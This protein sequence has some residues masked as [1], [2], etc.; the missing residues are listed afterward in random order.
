MS[1][2]KIA[3]SLLLLLVAASP[4]LAKPTETPVDL[5]EVSCV[6]IPG[7]TWTSGEMFHLRG[8]VSQSVLYD[9]ETLEVV[10]GNAILGNANLN[11]TTS[12]GVFFGT[13]SG[14]YLPASTTGTFDG[15]WTIHVSSGEFSGQAVARGTGE[16]EGQTMRVR[17]VGLTDAETAALLGELATQGRLPCP[18]ASIAGITRDIG[19]I[20]DPRGE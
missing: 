4:A 5:L 20:L 11:P 13:S 16:L 1:K 3:V 6:Q 8:Q 17:L 7:M 15:P 12:S 18:L 2:T 9:A 10:G 19:V 14:I